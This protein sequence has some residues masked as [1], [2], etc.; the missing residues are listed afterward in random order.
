MKNIRDFVKRAIRSTGFDLHRFTP[1]SNPSL[2]LVK[3]LA[4]FEVDLVLDVG[5]NIGQ[6]AAELRSY[7]FQ[8]NLVSFEPLSTA[9][10]VLSEAAIRDVGWKVHP[11]CAIGGEDGETVINVS[12]NSVSSSLLPMLKSHSSAAADS[13]YVGA[14]RTPIYRLDSVAPHYLQNANRPFLKIDTQGFEWSVLDG[15]KETLPQVRGILCELSLVPLYEGQ[16]LWREMIHRIEDLGFTLWAIQPGFVDSRD[17]RTLQ[18][19]AVFF[20]V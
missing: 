1:G 17:G 8:G 16:R 6:F 12:G 20:R 14:E 3:A 13:V 10:R 18:F 5:A 9:H 4:R 11:R 19:D 2:Q 15:A 7:G